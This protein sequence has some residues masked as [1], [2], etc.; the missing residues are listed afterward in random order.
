[1]NP[2]QFKD[3]V[4]QAGE[5]RPVLMHAEEFRRSKAADMEHAGRQL[6]Y[7]G[8]RVLGSAL[9]SLAFAKG[10]GAFWAGDD[11]DDSGDDA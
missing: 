11:S 3:P 9:A 8:R 2:R 1:M 10:R 4:V 7:R 5:L 6:A